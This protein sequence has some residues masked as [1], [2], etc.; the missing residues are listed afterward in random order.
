MKKKNNRTKPK[1]EQ[2]KQR[3]EIN[4]RNKTNKKKNEMK[5]KKVL[6]GA[7]LR[8]EKRQINLVNSETHLTPQGTEVAAVEMA[9]RRQGA[10]GNTGKAPSLIKAVVAM[11]ATMYLCRHFFF[12]FFWGATVKN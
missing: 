6:T 5:N 10:I 8:D 4:N 7:Q 3:I 1:N 11:V 9:T 2:P 12:S